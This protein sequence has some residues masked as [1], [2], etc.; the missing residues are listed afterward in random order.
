MNYKTCY[1]HN[2]YYE[3][4]FIL[5]QTWIFHQETAYNEQEGKYQIQHIGKIAHIDRKAKRDKQC[6]TFY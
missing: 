6:H 1:L 4:I 2:N 5:K 3:Q